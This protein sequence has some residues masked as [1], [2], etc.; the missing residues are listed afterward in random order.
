MF[1][2]VTGKKNFYF[3]GCG[4]PNKAVSWSKEDKLWITAMNQ[5]FESLYGKNTLKYIY[6]PGQGT[7]VQ[8]CDSPIPVFHYDHKVWEEN[9]ASYVGAIQSDFSKPVKSLK[10]QLDRCPL[11]SEKMSTSSTD[12]G[13][14]TDLAGTSFTEKMFAPS[15]DP[16]NV[17]DLSDTSFT[18][19]SD[20]S[21]PSKRGSHMLVAP[22]SSTGTVSKPGSV[23]STSASSVVHAGL[24]LLG[25][26][27]MTYHLDAWLTTLAGLTRKNLSNIAVPPPAAGPPFGGNITV[28]FGAYLES[29]PLSMKERP[30]EGL[31]TE[32]EK[33]FR[34]DPHSQQRPTG[35]VIGNL[36]T[37]SR[38]GVS[39]LR[40]F[41]EISS[42]KLSILSEERWLTENHDGLSVN[43]ISCIKEVLWNR[44]TSE[45]ILRAGR[46][47]LDV[48]SF[49]TLVGERYLDNFVI[50]VTIWCYLQDCQKRVNSET[51]YLPSEIHTWLE[52]SSHQFIERKLEEVMANAREEELELILCPLHML[53]SHWGLIV[54]DLLN[55]RLLFDDGYKLQPDACV[56][57]NIKYVLDIFRQLRPGALC[58]ENAFWGS[59]D[60]FERFGMP[61]QHGCA[62]AGQGTGSCGVGV[63]LAARDFLFKGVAGTVHQFGWKYTEMRPLRKH[64]MIQILKWGS[65]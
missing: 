32:A 10:P 35:V 14:A 11:Q 64:L 5:L 13:S 51:L 18:I 20:K 7:K 53:E 54:I 27:Q 17:T 63:I 43:E 1:N 23:V 2:P 60:Q 8:D 50:D 39:V 59:I 9:Y 38:D 58:F 57:P 41:C 4:W 61:S 49:S 3:R 19:I 55:R 15:L 42:L 40:K 22:S 33:A 28:L 26:S 31:V 56:L 47:S 29:D 34:N 30:A 12:S 24:T 36:G 44:R 21:S 52:T 6:V 16:G 62:R 25:Q 45:S 65:T 46:K 37:F 48:S